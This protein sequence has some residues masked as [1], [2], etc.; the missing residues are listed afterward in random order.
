MAD[1][2]ETEVA[3]TSWQ[4]FSRVVIE[5][6]RNGAP[7]VLCVEQRVTNLGEDQP[8][9]IQDIGNLGFP[10]DPAA[11]IPVVNPETM[12]PTGETITGMDIYVGI[13]SYVMMMA[14]ARDAALQ[15][16]PAPTEPPPQPE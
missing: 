7:S 16:T 14:A 4:R 3:G 11:V 8:E 1:Y 10:F 2:K 9:I 12:E 13:Y 6:P 5:N 15:P